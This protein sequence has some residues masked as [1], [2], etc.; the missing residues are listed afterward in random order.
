[1]KK[2]IYDIIPP[3][4][5]IIIQE[6]K[7]KKI[8]FPFGV[9]F[10]FIF[11]LS[12]FLYFFFLK[13]FSLSVY[14]TPQFEEKKFSDLI[15]IVWQEGIKDENYLFGDFFEFEEIFPFNFPSTGKTLTKAEGTLRLFNNYTTQREEWKKGTRFVSSEGKVFL[16]KDK[17][18]VPPATI[19]KGK[20]KSSFVDVPVIAQEPG[21]EGNIPPSKFSIPAFL[22]TERYPNYW[23]ESFEKMEGGGEKAS[24][25]QED[26]Q[27][28]KR[29]A[30]EKLNQL[31]ASY[32]KDKIGQDYYFV[33]DGFQFSILEEKL[34]AQV[35]QIIPSFNYSLRVK[36]LALFPKFQEVDSFAQKIFEKKI[37]QNE[38]FLPR[39]LNFVIRAKEKDFE[40]GIIKGELEL[41]GLTFLKLET[42]KIKRALEDEKIERVYEIVS[43]Y[44]LA[45]D[46][47][48]KKKYFFFFSFPEKEK[49]D[50]FLKVD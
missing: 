13:T 47:K 49:I 26:L 28:A 12:F 36:I 46:I 24:V 39:S 19:E 4:K 30:Q 10:I 31:V 48:V 22:G 8:K 32:L 38:L 20:I 27:E 44:Y 9:F 23:A 25:S 33:E 45:K 6:K 50:L 15:F 7:E 40:K 5:K 43:R 35:G 2:K 37:A 17:I 1:M 18:I 11:S 16:S 3:E 29:T 41:K 21:P 42:E 14:I 34:E